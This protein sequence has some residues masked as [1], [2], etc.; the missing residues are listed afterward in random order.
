M[1]HVHTSPQTH[2]TDQQGEFM[3]Q[4]PVMSTAIQEVFLLAWCTSHGAGTSQEHRG[5]PG[6]GTNPHTVDLSISMSSSQLLKSITYN[7]N[8]SKWPGKPT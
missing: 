2:P 7:T 8:K 3:P 6:G 1:H 5:S 4:G